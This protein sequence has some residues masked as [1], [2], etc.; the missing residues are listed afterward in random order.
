MLALVLI[1]TSSCKKDRT[2]LQG[3]QPTNSAFLKV[4]HAAPGFRKVFNVADSL[5]IIVGAINGQRL[6]AATPNS[7]TSA[8]TAPAPPFTYNSAFPTNTTNLNTYAAVPSGGQDIRLILRGSVNFDSV[9]IATI[10]KN[11]S[12]GM[13]YTLVITDSITTTSDYSKIWIQDNFTNPD[14][15]KYSIRCINAVMNDTAGKKI[16][17]YSFRSGANIFSNMSPGDVSAFNSLVIPSVFTDTFSVRRA[18]TTFELA[19]LNTVS[20]TNNSRVYTLLYRGDGT[21]T[22]GTK[23]RGIIVYNNK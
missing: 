16:D 5:N 7:A 19:R 15:G 8:L 4:I 12:P 20:I 1:I 10:P 3:V 9:T 13:Y 6:F 22:S 2:K 17:V 11:L 14:A 18:G 21:L 23:A